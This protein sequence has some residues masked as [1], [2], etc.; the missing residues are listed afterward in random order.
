GLGLH[1]TR[2]DSSAAQQHIEKYGV[3]IGWIKFAVTFTR[4]LIELNVH[5]TQTKWR[6]QCI[7]FN[8]IGSN[9]VAQPTKSI[10]ASQFVAP[11][12]F[13]TMVVNPDEQMPEGPT[14][15]PPLLREY[16]MELLDDV[17]KIYIQS[18]DKFPFETEM[19]LKK[20]YKLMNDKRQYI[21]YVAER[22]DFG[23]KCWRGMNRRYCM[24]FFSASGHLLY[25]SERR[26]IKCC[27]RLPPTQ[28]A[29]SANVFSSPNINFEMTDVLLA[30]GE[31]M[32]RLRNVSTFCKPRLCIDEHGYHNLIV[33]EGSSSG[34]IC[35]LINCKSSSFTIYDAHHYN[36]GR[37]KNKVVPEGSS[38]KDGKCVEASFPEN[39]SQITKALIIA[40][41]FELK[42]SFIDKRFSCE[43]V[44]HILMYIWMLAFC[45]TSVT[46]ILWYNGTLF[47]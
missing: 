43:S 25:T 23:S 38:P 44:I 27:S 17:H 41:A 42:I 2:H 19:H 15:L 4:N 16:G 21:F 26:R 46:L 45:G 6:N 1:D 14:H 34:N 32:G 37:V 18:T 29:V 39:I 13:I 33:V 30:S 24:Y 7:P 36:V 47:L 20:C 22:M 40:A 5:L 28:E 11:V 12:P 35:P 10:G 3:V 9:K 31:F 8:M